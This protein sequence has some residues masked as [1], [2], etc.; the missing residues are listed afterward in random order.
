MW[1]DHG[2]S[3]WH[4]EKL[5]SWMSLHHPHLSDGLSSFIVPGADGI[6]PV[7][8]VRAIS[9]D[10]KI[11]ALLDVRAQE[12]AKIM[13]H[14]R[15]VAM[16]LQARARAIRAGEWK[17]PLPVKLLADTADV[18][19]SIQVGRRSMF[20]KEWSYGNRGEPHGAWVRER[21]GEVRKQESG[22]RAPSGLTF[23]PD[24]CDL[25]W[26]SDGYQVGWWAFE[27]EEEARRSA[28]TD[29]TVNRVAPITNAI[30]L[31]EKMRAELLEENAK[32]V[33]VDVIEVKP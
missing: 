14:G 26:M 33:R 1:P 19:G 28:A 15:E 20:C 3:V 25:V 2:G 11:A 7:D 4:D 23:I 10:A 9:D 22:S 5:A 31:L 8:T 17:E 32:A 16:E 27:T 24:G 6:H 29:N 21:F 13:P 18:P 30:A 12:V